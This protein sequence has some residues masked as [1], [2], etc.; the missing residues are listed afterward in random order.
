MFRQSS[1]YPSVALLLIGLTIYLWPALIA[2][3]ALVPGHFDDTFVSLWALDWSARFLAGQASNLYFTFDLFAPGGASLLLHNL[4]ESLFLPGSI[5]TFCFSLPFAYT[6]F[7]LVLLL[8]N[9]VSALVLCRTLGACRWVAFSLALLF[10]FHPWILA[11]LAGGHLNLVG[12]F[13]LLFLSSALLRYA[14]HNAC[15]NFVNITFWTGFIA[16]T[17]YY[18]LWFGMLLALVIMSIE[19]VWRACLPLALG[20]CFAGPKLWMAA[21]LAASATYTPNHDPAGNGMDAVAFFAPGPTQLLRYLPMLSEL[22]STVALNFAESGLYLGL[23]VPLLLFLT[24]QFGNRKSS[25]AA[26]YILAG[27]MFLLVS[28]G[29]HLM[30]AGQRIVPLPFYRL[31]SL[32]PFVPPVP[33]RFGLPAIVC[34][35]IAGSMSI[36]TF[37]PKLR[38]LLAFVAIIEFWPASPHLFQLPN[39]P[40]LSVL[41]QLPNSGVVTD[42]STPERA[43]YHQLIHKKSISAGFLARRPRHG[44][45]RFYRRP[46]RLYLLEDGATL[47]AARQNLE[48]LK[49][50]TLLIP[51]GNSEIT[52][53][54]RL[55]FGHE[56]LSADDE[57]ELYVVRWPL[58]DQAAV[59][60]GA[61]LTK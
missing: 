11:H 43:T 16:F 32:L 51:A 53:R 25:R 24:Y 41:R 5:L 35:M 49:I 33:A 40:T 61:E 20:L 7:C 23:S 45:R 10:S 48:R 9:G 3:P 44:E 31:L 8:L 15:L 52:A 46:F 30:I 34:L 26:R 58:P 21:Q 1:I 57:T 6:L 50:Q 56:P 14:K 29:P 19:R 17:D 28:C 60:V 18:Q 13:P 42:L 36:H 38:W 27:V 37:S 55:L 12:V 39:S 47:T 4:A 59:S 54:A 22:R 2:A